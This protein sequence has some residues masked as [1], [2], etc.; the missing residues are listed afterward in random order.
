MLTLFRWTLRLTIGLILLMFL[1]ASLVWYFALRSL[2]DYNASHRISGISA[3]VEIVR[4]T[5]NVPHIFAANDHDAFFALGLVHAQDRLFQMT[6]LRR[7]AQGR[8]A[9]LYGERALPADDLMRRLGLA[10]IARASFPLQDERT[11]AA[12]AAYAEGVNQ[13]ITI[14]NEQALGRGAPEFFLLPDDIAYWEPADSL[15]ILKL[16]AAATSRQIPAEVLRAQ[17]SI[18]MPDR[19]QDIVAGLGEPPMPAYASLFPGARVGGIPAEGGAQWPLDL[20]GYLTPFTGLSGSSFAAEGQRT[21]TGQ[22]LLANDPEA[23]LTMP[24]LWY[25]ARLGLETGDVI[26][27]TIP[28]IP[29]IFS[30][31]SAELAWGMVPAQIDDADLLIE[32]IQPGDMNRYRGPGGWQDLAT[33]QEIIRIHNAQDRAITLRATENGPLLSG[34]SFGLASVTPV[35]HAVALAWTGLTPEDR[36]MSALIGIMAARDRASAQVA[37]ADWG[38]PAVRLTLADGEGIAELLVGL[39]PVRHPDHATLG[40][41]PAPGWVAAN[42]WQGLSRADMLDATLDGIDL[43]AGA[44]PLTAGEMPPGFDGDTG[45]R[46]NRL[47]H[48]LEGREV[49]SRGSFIDSQL[50]VVSPAA[51]ALLPLIGADL[52]FTG[53][54]APA[55][56]P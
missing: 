54:P 10:R 32:E 3:P 42:R 35:G 20:A 47:R 28:G 19:G 48:L 41:M 13:W 37:G 46:E 51:R 12:L 49:H 18:A 53:E 5:E 40:R 55:G 26:G 22:A 17:L 30:G 27:A 44:L 45:L 2:P 21:T 9:E 11:K 24:S 39:V 6:V 52:W 29:A 14:V 1:A 31:R 16:Y 38:A 36:T 50:D 4:S 34:G 43:A 15:A 25:L 7:A 56:T 33:R 23:A 8:L